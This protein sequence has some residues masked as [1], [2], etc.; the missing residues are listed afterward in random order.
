M[1]IIVLIL[2]K[3]A[4]LIWWKTEFNEMRIISHK[5]GQARVQLSMIHR[6]LTRHDTTGVNS[7]SE[8][9][10]TI[11]QAKLSWQC[12]SHY[13]MHIIK[14][15]FVPTPLQ[16]AAFLCVSYDF[17]LAAAAN[18]ALRCSAVMRVSPRN[19]SDERGADP[20]L[21]PWVGP[22]ASECPESWMN[23]RQGSRGQ[24]SGDTG[25]DQQLGQQRPLSLVV[26]A[27]SCW[28]RVAPPASVIT[29]VSPH[30]SL[31]RPVHST[32]GSQQWGLFSCLRL[33]RARGQSEPESSRQQDVQPE[34]RGHGVKT[35]ECTPEHGDIAQEES[36]NRLRKQT[37]LCF[38]IYTEAETR[39][40]R[41]SQGCSPIVYRKSLCQSLW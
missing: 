14:R 3:C 25:R 33:S 23:S 7:A 27:G 37:F 18:C 20:E 29:V 17:R 41:Q 34:R 26:E 32:E 30:T 9:H 21:R 22:G 12:K 40:S 2:K 13:S 38:V 31:P 28:P 39:E 16:P 8:Y 35:E 11:Y 19:T 10:V 5:T 6:Q 36:F 24:E 15:N 4:S 1:S